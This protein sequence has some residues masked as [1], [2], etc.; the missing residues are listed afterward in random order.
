MGRFS[1]VLFDWDGTLADTW[2]LRVAFL[3]HLIERFGLPVPDVEELRRNFRADYREHYAASG[4]SERQR[5]Q[6]NMIWNAYKVGREQYSLFPGVMETIGTLSMRGVKLGVVSNGARVE[7]IQ[8]TERFGIRRYL[9]CIVTLDDVPEFKPSPEG[10]LHAIRLLGSSEKNTLYVGD[11]IEDVRAGKS[12]G[13]ATAAVTSGMH[14]RD[15]LE[16]EKPNYLFGSVNE[17]L[18]L[19]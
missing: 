8:D 7:V 9:G 6:T 15:M 16:N 19:F 17:L 2:K 14:F 1:T 4:L 11:M 10:I 18:G 5:Q 13:V 3:A 12:A